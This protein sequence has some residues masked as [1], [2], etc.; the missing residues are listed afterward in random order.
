M[1]EMAVKM[2]S[3]TPSVMP[4]SPLLMDKKLGLL[5]HKMEGLSVVKSIT[6]RR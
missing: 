3:V 5:C 4:H 1:E 2:S 6:G